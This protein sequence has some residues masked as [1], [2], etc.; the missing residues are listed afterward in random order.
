MSATLRIALTGGIGSGKTTI[1]N[2]FQKLGVP[3][4]DADVISKNIVAPD[5]P[6]FQKIISEFGSELLT[7]D[8][9]LDRNKLRK[10]IFSNNLA[11]KTLED[12]LHPAIYNDI[13]AQISNIDY[14]YC[15][16]VVPL[17]IETNAV[18]RFDKVLVADTPEDIQIMRASNRDNSS[19][20]EIKKIIKSQASQKQRLKIA[21]D[22]IN[23][24]LTIE[25]LKS[26]VTNLHEK[27]IKLSSYNFKKN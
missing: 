17:L 22:V 5:K 1:A 11:K 7:K 9:T 19:K 12:I 15:L 3:I 25:E 23:N 27:Y 20:E 14:P 26:H 18:G 2:E 16:I 8:G 4:I 10:I 21:D 13:E 24:S 6:C